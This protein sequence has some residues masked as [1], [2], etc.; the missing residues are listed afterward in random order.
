MCQA[1]CLF[2]LIVIGAVD[3]PVTYIVVLCF[4]KLCK[5]N[6]SL[7]FYIMENNFPSLIVC[8]Y[9]GHI[10][11]YID[12]FV[13]KV[14]NTRNANYAYAK[15]HISRANSCSW[16]K[17]RYVISYPCRKFRQIIWTKATNTVLVIGGISFLALPGLSLWVKQV[18]YPHKSIRYN[19]SYMRPI[20]QQFK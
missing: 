4:A 19:L 18:I 1:L 3:K 5:M 10:Y 15:P 20:L 9:I 2:F 7:M 16:N 6:G 13:F 12:N 11:M 14:V 17:K 8:M